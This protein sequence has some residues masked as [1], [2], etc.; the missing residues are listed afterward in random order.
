MPPK[1]PDILARLRQDHKA[2]K[3]LLGKLEKTTERGASTRRKLVDKIATELEAHTEA[4][5]TTFYQAIHDLAKKKDDEEMFYEA[6]EEHHVVDLVL[7][8]LRDTDPAT[9][10]FAAKAKVL[11]ELVEHHIKE[12]E[13]QMFKRA[14]TLFSK[15]ELVE[16]GQE[17]AARKKQLS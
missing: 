11:K 15:E 10:Q 13:N 16:L 14:R 3:E 2:V 5:E 1:N 8:E 6:H 7:P 17:F 4:E 9:P 12:E